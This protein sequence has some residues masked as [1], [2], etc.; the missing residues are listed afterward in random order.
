V[1]F[2]QRSES[3]SRIVSRV[4]GSDAVT[5]T[6][7]TNPGTMMTVRPKAIP[8]TTVETRAIAGVMQMA[9]VIAA[10]AETTPKPTQRSPR[11]WTPEVLAED[12]SMTEST[13]V[14]A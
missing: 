14:A 8:K 6:R 2:S 4:R 7:I 13:T 12:Q 9:I 3:V 1:I 5:D 10:K 11:S